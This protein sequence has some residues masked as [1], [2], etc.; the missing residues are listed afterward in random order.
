MKWIDDKLIESTYLFCAKR[1][2]NSEEAK[3]LAHDILYEAIRTLSL[4]REFSSFYSWYWKMARNK[5][6]DCIRH[7]QSP[8]LPIEAAGG[9]VFDTPPPI[10]RLILKEDIAALN[11]S[12][13]RLAS[14]Y[15]KIMIRYYLREQ[16]VADIAD[17]LGL[18][19]GTV[20]RRLFDARKQ[21]KERIENMNNIGK[22]S[23]APAQAEWF[24]GGLAEQASRL[25]ESS[26]IIPQIMVIC[27]SEQKT[28]NDI[29]DEMGIA[30]VYLEEILGKMTE[31]QLL[32]SPA[33]EK[34]LANFCVFPKQIY[35]ET[36]LYAN[37][38]FYEN[39]FPERVTEKLL[40][41]KEKITSLSFY[42]NDFDYRYLMW[43]IYAEAENI[44]GEEGRLKHLEKY[45]GKLTDDGRKYH[46]TMQY[47]L[48]DESFDELIFKEIKAV[49]WSC[50]QQSFGTGNYGRVTF[51]NNFEAEP[52]PND[53][54]HSEDW[55]R[56]RDMWV[57]GNNIS[58]LFDLV[59]YPQ[60]VLSEFEEEKAADFLKKGLLKKEGECFTVQLPIFLRAIYEDMREIIR[61]EIGELAREYAD[62]IGSEVEKRL[63]PYVRKDMLN[64]FLYF[65]MR[66]FFQ[67]TGGLFWYGWDKYLALPEDY[68][69]SAAGLY[70]MK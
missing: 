35:T 67:I 7:K 26:K 23:Y 64:N 60:K 20:K 63:L 22:S 39:G 28:V 46:L 16:S 58:L 66:I 52:F 54:V 38:V 9:A 14:S 50:L 27:R 49:N 8:D 2:S 4:G 36:V 65:D 57:D 17:D 25:M 40:A 62:I 15:R 61:A 42:G 11:Y 45:K 3:D 51:V 24:W 53:K 68:T 12:L 10:E 69:C 48:P 18:P 59:K 43:L 70:L 29:A 13:S 37:K 33:K 41:A 1:L 6:A 32:L 21:V 5:Y 56:G 30:P 31:E 19:V 55:L 44:F 47:L 34:Y